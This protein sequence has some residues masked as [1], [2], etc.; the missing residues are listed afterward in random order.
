MP[1]WEGVSLALLACSSGALDVQVTSD[2]MADPG[3]A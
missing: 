2:A 3:A 1:I